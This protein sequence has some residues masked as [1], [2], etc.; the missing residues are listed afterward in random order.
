M[1]DRTALEGIR[2]I[3]FS[4]VFQGPVA[5]QLLGDLG[6]DVIKVERPDGGDWSRR[7]GPYVRGMS[8]PFV[9]LNRN[10]RSI[11]LDLKNETGRRLLLELVMTADVLVHNFRPG[12]MERLGMGYEDLREIHPRLVYARSSGWG[13]LGPYV[14]RGRPGHDMMARAAAGLFAPL[15][16]DGLPVTTGVSVDYPTGM[17][18]AIGILVALRARERTGRGQLVSTDLFSV[19]LHSHAWSGANALNEDQVDDT[20]GVGASEKAIQTSF[21]TKDGSIEI[22]PVFSDDPLR[23]ISLALGLGDLS[24]D[25]RFADKAARPSRSEEINALLQE[26]LLQKSTD[27]WLSILEP[28]GVLC[29]RINTFTEGIKDP[30]AQANGMVVEMPHKRMGTARMLGTP[31]RLS[32]TPPTLRIAPPELGEHTEEVIAE[33]GYSK[34][35]IGA[36]REQRAFG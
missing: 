4:H 32:D 16:P 20:S 12:V 1:V 13:D 5:M 33:L 34:D 27:E 24:Q 14:E 18:L 31:L 8:L 26:R 3:D 36:F 21:W 7:W 30:Q 19:A 10:K 9:S 2:I 11:T 22:S 35:E 28:Q 15:G 23:D 25:P 6:A 29:S 17:M